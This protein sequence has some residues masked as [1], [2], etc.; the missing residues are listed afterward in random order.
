MVDFR[1]Q[2]TPENTNYLKRDVSDYF[3]W[4][5]TNDIKLGSLIRNLFNPAF[6]I[7]YFDRMVGWI[8]QDD[9]IDNNYYYKLSESTPDRNHYQLCPFVVSV[10]EANEIQAS[11]HYVDIVNSLRSQGALTGNVNRLFRSNTKSWCPPI[12]PDMLVNFTQYIWSP[13]GT[14]VYEIHSETNLTDDLIGQKHATLT[15][16]TTHTVLDDNPNSP[17]YGQNVEVHDTIEVLSGM[18]IR[19]YNDKNNDYNNI[20]YIINGVG[21][22]I[23]IQ[24][25]REFGNVYEYN[26]YADLPEVGSSENNEI[27]AV[28]DINTL[29]KWNSEKETYEVFKLETSDIIPDYVT[30]QRQSED[31]NDWSMNNRW[32]NFAL[33]N[34]DR[35]YYLENSV[36]ANHQ[37]IQFVKNLKLY[38][39]GEKVVETVDC[40]YEGNLNSLFG[41][42]EGYQIPSIDPNKPNPTLK[43]GMKILVKNTLS[44]AELEEIYVVSGASQGVSNLSKVEITFSENDEVVIKE[45]Y[46][47]GIVYWSGGEFLDC[48][49]RKDTKYILFDLFDENHVKLDNKYTYTNS[50][51]KGSKL[52]GYKL[53]ENGREEHTDYVCYME[54]DLGDISGYFYDFVSDSY[55]TFLNETTRD[56]E[57]SYVQFFY[58]KDNS[59]NYTLDLVPDSVTSVTVNTKDVSNYVING[60]VISFNSP[61]SVNDIIKVVFRYEGD[62]PDNLQNAYIEPTKLLTVLPENEGITEIPYNTLL[63]Q[64]IDII[65]NQTDFTGSA[66]SQN[67]YYSSE[68]DISLGTKI[69]VSYS[70]LDRLAII[71]SMEGVDIKS[72]IMKISEKYTEFMYRFIQRVDFISRRDGFTEE[73]ASD[74]AQLSQV[75]L[76]ILNYLSL[77]KTEN[78]A[79]Y[80]NGVISDTSY[81]PATPAYLGLIPCIE[82]RIENGYIYGHDGSVQPVHFGD[83]RDQAQ[84]ML[85]QMIYDSINPEFKEN[86]G[87][88]EY[89]QYIPSYNKDTDYTYSEYIELS[90]E[91]F[92]KWFNTHID[93]T[94]TNYSYSEDP[95]T[96]NWSSCVDFNGN[97]LLGHY[98]GIYNYF[99]GTYQP[100]K[101]PW[102]M[103]GFISK[104]SWWDEQYGE[105][106]YTSNNLILWQDIADGII[107]QGKEAGT[108]DYLKRPY[109]LKII[110]V[111]EE[112]NLLPPNLCGITQE[113]PM[114]MEARKSFVYGDGSDAEYDWWQTSD[115]RF[116]LMATLYLMKP[117]FWLE[118]TWDS[119]ADKSQY[120]LSENIHNL[121]L[122]GV[123]QK[124]IGTAQ[125]VSDF[126]SIRGI[127]IEN[128]YN[129]LKNREIRLGY[130]VGSYLDYGN[131]SIKNVDNEVLLSTDYQVITYKS[132]VIR[133][134]SMSSMKIAWVDGKY[135]IYGCDINEPYFR[136]LS[137]DTD[138]NYTFD[139]STQLNIFYFRSWND[140]GEKIPYYTVVDSIQEV[141]NIIRG[142]GKYL[143]SIGFIFNTYDQSSQIVVDWDTM[144]KNF[145]SW[146]VSSVREDRDELTLSP[147][148]ILNLST[149]YPHSY[150]A[151]ENNFGLIG[152]ICSYTNNIWN[153]LDT[154]GNA[155]LPDN[156][157]V[158]RQIN[159]CVIETSDMTQISYIHINVY[160]QENAIIFNSET[161]G[162]YRLYH[163]L[164]GETISNLYIESVRTAI[165]DGGLYAPGLILN[166]EQVIYNFTTR[167]YNFKDYYDID[168]ITAVEPLGIIAKT[169]TGYEQ[170]VLLNNIF[171][172]EM[173]EF[174]F[175]NA[176]KMDKGSMNIIKA[177]RRLPD[178][179]SINVFEIFALLIQEYGA[180]LNYKELEI[181]ANGD[182]NTNNPQIFTL[183]TFKKYRELM[184]IVGSPKMISDSV[185]TTDKD[186]Y[187]KT[188]NSFEPFGFN[189]NIHIKLAVDDFTKEDGVRPV[190]AGTKNTTPKLYVDDE[191]NTIVLRIY[192][193]SEKEEDYQY[194]SIDTIYVG[195][196]YYIEYGRKDNTYY[197]R[198][199]TD[200]A[201]WSE[202]SFTA[203]TIYD[204]NDAALYI[205][206]DNEG[207]S[208]TEGRIILDGFTNSLDSNFVGTINRNVNNLY[209]D[210]EE[211]ITQTEFVDD[212]RFR[213]IDYET[214]DRPFL[215]QIPLLKIDETQ[216]KITNES[217]L[218]NLLTNSNV[219]STDKILVTFPTDKDWDILQVKVT[220]H[221]KSISFDNEV[222]RYG[223]EAIFKTEL[224]H[225]LEEGQ[226]IRINSMMKE[227]QSWD[228]VQTVLAV[229]DEYS[230]TILTSVQTEYTFE[231]KHLP[232]LSEIFSRKFVTKEEID[233]RYVEDGDLFF[234]EKYWTTGNRPR[235]AIFRWSGDKLV[236]HRLE[237]DKIDTSLVRQVLLY[238][239]NNP[240]EYT[241][242]QIFDPYKYIIDLETKKNL[243]Y[244][245]SNDPAR[246]SVDRL[247]DTESTWGNWEN[248]HIG[249]TW[250]DT[251]K[252]KYFDYEIE[253]DAY[254]TKMWGKM[255]LGS[256]IR[257]YEWV[258]S[259]VA[260]SEYENAVADKEE[261]DGYTLSGTPYYVM[262]GE[263][264]IYPYNT[265][266]EY[267]DQT[268]SDKLWYYF[269]VEY[270][271]YV[272]NKINRT[273]STYSMVLR[274]NSDM[275][276]SKWFAPISSKLNSDATYSSSFILANADGLNDSDNVLQLKYQLVENNYP[277]HKDWLFFHKALSN[278]KYLG[279][280]EK[281]KDSISGYNS[282][283]EAVPYVLLNEYEKNGVWDH[284]MQSMYNDK[285]NAVKNIIQKTNDMLSVINLDVN[286]INAFNIENMP[287]VEEYEDYLYGEKSEDDQYYV[288]KIIPNPDLDGSEYQVLS[289]S[290]YKIIN[291]NNSNN[292]DNWLWEE[293]P[294]YNYINFTGQVIKKPVMAFETYADMENALIEIGFNNDDLLYVHNDVNQGNHWTIYKIH[295]NEPE[296][297][298]VQM[299]KMSDYYEYTDWYQSGIDNF[300]I[301]VKTY[302]YVSDIERDTSYAPKAGDMVK[303]IHGNGDNWSI[304]QYSDNTWKTVAN[305]N[306]TIRFTDAILNIDTSDPLSNSSKLFALVVRNILR[307]FED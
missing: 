78:D 204:M 97:N 228:G 61:L 63:S 144:A 20:V 267:D 215:P 93:E 297:Y 169:I 25:D 115:Y 158:Y 191:N 172:N 55:K 102:E 125:W 227:K 287:V 298:M 154:D 149:R 282:N 249:E 202:K 217:E 29:Y 303:I 241:Q 36:K 164:N 146:C 281:F 194:L 59:L 265:K 186:N 254:R 230:F 38:H 94:F 244:I 296:L 279:Y 116:A 69:F 181:K 231:E 108:Y 26:T 243:N 255:V 274:I 280:W 238:D 179:Q 54:Q 129:L 16:D 192:N 30:M 170:N 171:T 137:P 209:I 184:D 83:W 236:I 246:Y 139:K 89:K 46:R 123:R 262:K 307:L 58:V 27:Y 72:I 6:E 131:L 210:S 275:N 47:K 301:I 74:E 73:M 173:A 271:Q 31:M 85:E 35:T 293:A 199:T 64:M 52:F 15:L 136:I 13:L 120:Q 178:L 82:P 195:S 80:N 253:D 240:E 151:F 111:D 33:M 70:R 28:L 132:S 239:K 65:S 264:R 188:K 18:R 237:Q 187:I 163:P 40:Y 130:R 218:T 49:I 261:V 200:N 112:G 122:D 196:T 266:I 2:P 1:F 99:Y 220:N 182:W 91:M 110:P 67:N 32:F 290:N 306:G 247:T 51:F 161:E 62:C 221:I 175:F 270:T 160:S 87:I 189:W 134:A 277:L 300:N 206:F 156:I 276:Q 34:N 232:T 304:V 135:I 256:E 165:W 103:L 283:W 48:M 124:V 147:W 53:D 84:L 50:T 223:R 305:Q 5:F 224:P 14:R 150:I 286:T 24:D 226:L 68:Q 142:Y 100:D 133:S 248:N 294:E 269:W 9:Y 140:E 214:Y 101:A 299:Y 284:P 153:V 176:S 242:F 235:N 216:Y 3:S 41:K 162:G 57:S 168:S 95:F 177:L 278:E 145:L 289:E 183:N 213:M 201:T 17:T 113:T 21:R 60:P 166:D 45:G 44:E 66:W 234:V 81:I 107:R 39:H 8:G 4:K 96:W 76:D 302:D 128:L 205:G 185:Y 157:N 22:S 174:D 23:T 203:D 121:V 10:N 114:E 263:T 155:I 250:W 198:W 109:L 119:L 75:V 148:N 273:L 258:K 292:P 245:N 138:S 86:L 43:D 207:N 257:I 167:A 126:L 90:D 222:D 193:G 288:F 268:K 295:N 19:V 127:A 79:F 117:G 225:G 272:P 208:W 233:T 190:I 77:G 211:W 229:K 159:G 104:P 12:D 219:L 7:P 98:R 251:S 141:Y 285:K 143:E 291:Q 259:P 152:N 260:P 212:N 88:L 42:N 197:L 252:C 56:I 118:Y 106:P 11:I 37:I 92:A 105:A 71:N 180:I